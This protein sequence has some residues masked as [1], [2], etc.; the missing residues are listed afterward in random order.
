MGT[1]PRSRDAITLG[2][3]GAVV[4]GALVLVVCVWLTVWT[5]GAR[6]AYRPYPVSFSVPDAVLAAAVSS[7]TPPPG[8]NDWSCKPGAAHPRPVVLVHGLL[9]NMVDDWDTMAPLLADNGFCVYTFTYG[10][11]PGEA[12]FGGVQPMEQSAPQLA[13]FVARVLAATGASKVDLVGHSEGT[14]MPRYYMEFLGGAAKVDHYVMLT[15]IW[16]GTDVGGL[17]TVEALGAELDPSAIATVNALFGTATTCASCSEFLTGSSF[18][19]HLNAGGMA[20][21]GVTYTNIVTKYDELVVPYTS[22]LLTAPGV[23]NFTLQDQCPTDFSDHLTVAFDP[24]A[25]QDMLNALDPT[26]ARPVPCTVV[27]PGVGAPLPPGGVG[28]G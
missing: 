18:M 7:T 14:L 12:Y 2:R 5:P 1:L 26:H 27:L 22:G 19:Q 8:A 16:H 9:A 4:A 20:L 28:L 11:D 17:A 10:T 13:A 15:P 21:P 6:A 3:R 23:T 24:T 25:A